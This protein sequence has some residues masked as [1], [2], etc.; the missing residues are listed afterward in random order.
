MKI[1]EV[2]SG[3]SGIGGINKK[4]MGEHKVG[5]YKITIISKSI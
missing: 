4:D 5:L 2:A 3:M 1:D